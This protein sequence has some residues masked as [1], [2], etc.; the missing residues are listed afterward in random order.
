[1]FFRQLINYIDNQVVYRGNHHTAPNV[2]KL[3]SEAQ[4][5]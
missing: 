3:V 4:I 1:M 2:S 5:N